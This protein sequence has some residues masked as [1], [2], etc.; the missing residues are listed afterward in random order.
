M[1]KKNTKIL[2][3]GAGISGIRAALDL[4]E[5]GH[6]V[7]LIDK[8]PAMGGI[9]T[10]L[11]HQ[12][13]NNHCG[14]CR[15][16]PM[17]DRDKG[18][19][20]CLRKGLFHENIEIML[21]SDVVSVEGNPGKL[22]V[23]IVKQPKGVDPGR[24]IGCK[25]CETVC[26]VE[27]SDGF[28]AGLGSRKAVYLPVPHQLPNSRVIDWENCTQCGECKKA[29][30]SDAIDLADDP[31][32]MVL[33]DIS[34]VVLSTG[35]ELYDP[36]Q[37][38]VYGVGHFSNV[39]TATAFERIMS[40]SGPYKGKLL[41]PSDGKPPEKIAWVQCVGSRNLMIGADYC[42]SA[43]CMFAVKEAV[44]AK[45]K[46]GKNIDTA[47]MYMDMRT[48]GRD[49]QRYR[50]SAEQESGVRFIKCRIHSIE[51]AENKD[52]I[53]ISYIDSSGNQV[54][55]T[56]DMAVLSTGRRPDHKLPEFATHEG[57]YTVNSA[58]GFMDI[59]GSVI[60]ACAVSVDVGKLL[61]LSDIT[62]LKHEQGAEETGIIC[63]EKPH[64][65]VVLCSCADT[66]DHIISW[67]MIEKKLKNLPGNIDITRIKLV[68]TQ[69][70][71]DELKQTVKQ[72]PANRLLIASC[73]PLIYL[74]R[75]RELVQDTGIPRSFMEMI[76][77]RSIADKTSDSTFVT[78]SA[79]YELES[80]I[81]RLLNRKIKEPVCRT[82]KNNALVVG[83]G[84]AGLSAAVSLSAQKIPV[85]LVEKTDK[86]GG[87]YP[88]M[89]PGKEKNDVGNLMAEVENSP[90]ITVLYNSEVLQTFG[91]PGQFVSRI[92]SMSGDETPV[93]HGA[94]IIAIG[95]TNVKTDSFCYGTN[96]RIVTIFELEKQLERPEF[97]ASSIN[98][99]VFI[100]CVDSR[101][102]PRNYCSRICCLK[103][104]KASIKIMEKNPDAR[105][106][107]FYR[108]IMAYGESEKFYTEARKNGVMF[109]PYT[110]D[111]KPVVSDDSGEVV[112]QGNDPVLSEPVTFKPDL[113]VLAT[114]V[115]PHSAE[116]IVGAGD[117]NTTADGFIQEADS[118]WRPVDSGREG[119][120]VCGLARNPVRAD[121]AMDEG[122]AAAQRALRILSKET[123]KSSE[124]V[125]NV[126]HAYC[127]LCETCIHVCPYDARYADPE[128][129]KIMVDH[130]A[131]QGCGTCAAYCPNS[132]SVL[133][134]F[135]ENGIMDMI[136]TAL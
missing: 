32:E 17:I 113:L 119:V 95:G 6:N 73:N 37:T 51:P 128:I 27:I 58:Q 5:L 133:G 28:N 99:A 121:E 135:E 106:Y 77:L 45:E 4:A 115:V 34:A 100:Q 126:R 8:A 18:P 96:D 91:L 92:R 69:D 38:D 72:G 122:R 66:L 120:F 93:H 26:P 112:I 110:P 108:D 21:S 109:I 29:C 134:C 54:E 41:R 52:D 71:W 131:C 76:N 62:P 79:I 24:C 9:L 1:D 53:T 68:C 78:D 111:T 117:I 124:Q 25:E 104:L 44:L 64:L 114:G 125:A 70:G 16:L 39:V 3:V 94:A 132:A 63:E 123:L 129:G 59:S 42:S 57:V 80:G 60:S 101:E 23:T 86:L 105:V 2:V 103:S 75:L 55:E 30:S 56:F 81:N 98:T 82:V 31:E 136:E 116:N 15:M 12:F 33:E 43:C 47:I 10:R 89:L 65:Q 127:S 36:A 46:F 13:P 67:D 48:F 118:K 97:S 90:I 83:G 7:C 84:P 14:M 35:I 49:F 61:S 11:D 20:F 50:D 22:T 40:S 87:N 107:I 88:D 19:Q 102:E 74:P 85:T 130:V